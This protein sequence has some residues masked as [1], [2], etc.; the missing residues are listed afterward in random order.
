MSIACAILNVCRYGVEAMRLEKSC[1]AVIY[2][3]CID[4]IEYL[5]IQ[6]RHGQHFSF[7]K[8]HKEKNETDIET[9]LR[10]VSEETGLH[11]HLFYELHMTI[12]YQPK[13][14]ITKEVVLFLAEAHEQQVIIQEDE[15]IGFEWL[16]ESDVILRLTYQTDREVFSFL[17][18]GL[19]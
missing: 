3:R 14:D 16:K 19:S 11:V 9:A 1:G 18:K 7:P 8:G 13:P 6:H 17:T 5:V 12:Q 15:I 10:E 2:R 4:H